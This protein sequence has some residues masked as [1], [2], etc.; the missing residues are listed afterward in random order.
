MKSIFITGGTTGIGLEL[1]KHYLSDG[2]R[3]GLCGRNAEKLPP[4]FL[5]RYPRGQFFELDVTKREEVKKTVAAFA[6]EGLDVV[7]A[8]AGVALGKKS[9]VPDFQAAHEVL[10]I[11]TMG[12]LYTFEAA[13]PFFEE[14]KQGHFVGMAS[15][16]GFQGLP[17]S[18][19]Y[20]ASKAAVITMCES[21]AIDLKSLNIAITTIC[22]GFIDTP[23][24]QVNPHPMPFLMSAPRAAKKIVKA[25]EKKKELYLFPWPMA[26]LIWAISHMPRAP[27][28]WL[29]RT[30]MANHSVPSWDHPA[31]AETKGESR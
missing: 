12:L 13:F 6:Q 28:R 4:D 9:T 3:V 18:A 14:Q 21:W 2:H 27:Y 30:P 29:M 17:G 20:S 1:A 19:A 11:N 5:A 23:L 8:N 22:P 10:S 7:V 15:V 16:A 25:I 26:C 24:T 31:P